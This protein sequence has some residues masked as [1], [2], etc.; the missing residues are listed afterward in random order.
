MD[1]DTEVRLREL[2]T[3]VT[4]IQKDLADLGAQRRLVDACNRDGPCLACIATSY[5][6]RLRQAL[7]EAEASTEVEGER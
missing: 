2:V 1:K 5:A 7:G 3:E 6:D 4:Q